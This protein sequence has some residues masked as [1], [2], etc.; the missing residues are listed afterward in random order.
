MNK[1]PESL[2]FALAAELS[3]QQLD[4]YYFTMESEDG[5]LVSYYWHSGR[6]IV[7]RVTGPDGEELELSAPELVEW[8]SRVEATV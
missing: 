6:A 1:T 3:G 2:S 5:E 4:E 7:D 8:S